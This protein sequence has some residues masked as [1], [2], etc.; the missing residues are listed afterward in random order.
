LRWRP[1]H[2]GSDFVEQPVAEF[3]FEKLAVG[4]LRDVKRLVDMYR[5]EVEVVAFVRDG[6]Q[7]MDEKERAWRSELAS[8]RAQLIV[9][10]LEGLGSPRGSFHAQ[11][12]DE[13]PGVDIC[14]RFHLDG[15]AAADQRPANGEE[16]E[17]AR[18]LLADDSPERKASRS[19]TRPKSAGRLMAALKAAPAVAGEVKVEPK[20]QPEEEV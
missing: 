14:F 10:S 4:T 15:S 6:G 9:R 17:Q 5:V 2:Y 11:V 12:G 13:G 19:A 1:R 16:K 18:K 7:A 20:Q 8:S 3:E